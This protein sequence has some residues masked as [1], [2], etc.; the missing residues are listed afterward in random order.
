MCTFSTCVM[1]SNTT[2]TPHTGTAPLGLH[3]MGLKLLQRRLQMFWE[4]SSR[5]LYIWMRS[6]DPLYVLFNWNQ[7][8]S[9]TLRWTR[10]L[11]CKLWTFQKSLMVLSDLRVHWRDVTRLISQK[12]TVWIYYSQPRVPKSG[13]RKKVLY[14]LLKV[15][16]P[17]SR[18]KFIRWVS[19]A[20]K[21]SILFVGKYATL[22]AEKWVQCTLRRTTSL[23]MRSFI[24]IDFP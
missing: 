12:T 3:K 8:H 22:R 10:I 14:Q 15:H 1:A 23:T 19:V 16:C 24:A 7:L 11:Y 6:Y 17:C 5:D 21:L 2:S 18:A 9:W 13:T 20:R 4:K